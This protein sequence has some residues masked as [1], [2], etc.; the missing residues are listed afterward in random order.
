ML[1][2]IV[3]CR[4][5]AAHAQPAADSVRSVI[6]RMFDAMKRSDSSALRS[7]FVDTPLLQTVG[8]D[9]QGTTVIRNETLDGFLV[10]VAQQR[11]GAL[12]ERVLFETVRVDGLLA[13]AWTPYRFY[14]KGGFSH[15]GVNSFQLVHTAGAWRIQ[16]LIDTR[17]RQ[18]CEPE[19]PPGN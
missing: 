10:Q 4:N 11:P 6:A 3:V 1:L 19:P 15:C 5:P 2:T 14:Y 9:V 18:D 7:C 17:R 8:R 13:M 12:D 16:Y